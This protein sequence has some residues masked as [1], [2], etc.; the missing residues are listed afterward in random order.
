MSDVEQLVV[1]ATEQI[2]QS[3]TIDA[4]EQVRIDYLGKKGLITALM[5]TLGKLEPEQRATMGQVINQAKQTV[6]SQI[7]AKK[8]EIQSAALNAKLASETID[9]SLPG[10]GHKSAGLHPVTR[11]L[12][13]IEKLFADMGFAVKTGPEIEDDYHNFEA[14]NIPQHH[15]ARAMH[16]TFYIDKASLKSV[17]RDLESNKKEYVFSVANLS[18]EDWLKFPS[19]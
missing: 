1:Q 2:K 13:R 4:I 15:P 8:E 6:Q 9:V 10:R 5:K 17:T 3:T 14:L 7:Q 19:Q 12:Q 18:K 11:T 16:D